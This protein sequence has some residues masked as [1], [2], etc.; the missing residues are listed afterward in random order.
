MLH[1]SRTALAGAAALLALLA[2]AL[3]AAAQTWQQPKEFQ[4]PRDTW[5][6]PGE[7]Q[8]PKGIQAIRAEERNHPGRQF[9]AGDAFV[10][11]V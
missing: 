3:P 6:Q 1:R 11:G 4:K 8:I 2:P 5:Q 9:V 10:T 7:I